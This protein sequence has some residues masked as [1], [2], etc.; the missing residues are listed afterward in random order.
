MDDLARPSHR[1]FGANERCA[2]PIERAVSAASRSKP[3]APATTGRAGDSSRGAAEIRRRPTPPT[4]TGSRNARLAWSGSKRPMAQDQTQ[5]RR[6]SPTIRGDG[7]LRRVVRDTVWGIMNSM[8]SHLEGTQKPPIWRVRSRPHRRSL[9][10][11]RR[12]GWRRRS[13]RSSSISA[14][15]AGSRPTGPSSADTSARGRAARKPRHLDRRTGAR[16]AGHGGGRCEEQTMR[17]FVSI[18]A[19]TSSTRSTRS[20]STLIDV[21]LVLLI[22]L[23]GCGAAATGTSANLPN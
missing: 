20:T 22:I 9:A 3:S 5:H 19:R 13:R 8:S 12:R 23:H 10:C 18:T 1:A 11:D 21:M 17:V 15:R 7:A 14:S 16:Q 6:C 2:P 4:R